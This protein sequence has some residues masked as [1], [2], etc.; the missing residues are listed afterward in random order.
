MGRKNIVEFVYNCEE[1]IKN[2][3]NEI[4]KISFFNSMK[5]LNAFHNNRISL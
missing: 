3:L 2:E 5:V 1:S 4:D